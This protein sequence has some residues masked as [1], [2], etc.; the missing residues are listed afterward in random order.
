MYP[1]RIV[2]ICG[3]LRSGSYNRRLLTLTE[4]ILKKL[5]VEVDSLDLR[6]FEMPIYDGDYE[7][8]H[9]IPETVWKLKSRLAASHGIIIASPE[10]NAGVP[11][12]LKNAIDWSSRGE[13]PPWPAKIVGL[14]GV[15]AGA[16]GTVRMMPQLR[17]TLVMLG[18]T[19]I[20][21]QINVPHAGSVWDES[22][23]LLDGKLADRVEK[24]CRELVRV[25]SRL[26]TT[27]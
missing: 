8:E 22:G 23:S 3:S 7:Q 21:R 13:S 16:W 24:F 26:K 2:T 10:Y 17:E 18:A 1:L 5:D 15:S 12:V 20:S 11:P 6:E 27:A 9:G 14:M 19:V 4:D 25:V